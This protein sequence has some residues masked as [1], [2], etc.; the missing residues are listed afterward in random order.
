M[1]LALSIVINTALRTKIAKWLPK[2]Y[3]APRYNME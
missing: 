2:L 3:T 1:R